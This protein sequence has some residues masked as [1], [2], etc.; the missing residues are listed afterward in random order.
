MKRGM[1]LIEVLV[2]LT[3]LTAVTAAS[4][5]WTTIAG[6]ATSTHL[7][8]GRWRSAATSVLQLIHD[9]IGTG[10]F[11]PQSTRSPEK[12]SPRVIVE[13]GTLSIR[14]RITYSPPEGV[15]PTRHYG[16]DGISHALLTSTEIHSQ[17]QRLLLT[18]VDEFSCAM[19][20]A[21]TQLT[22]TIG[23]SHFGSVDRSYPL[24]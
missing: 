5:A 23:S 2:S 8:P 9:D 15:A 10:D 4:A 21:R 13:G 17:E 3:L 20:E 14:T 6:H 24:P 12:E 7:E 1:T 18:G 22:V 11:E 16:L 19:D